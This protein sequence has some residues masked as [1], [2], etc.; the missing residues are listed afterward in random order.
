MLNPSISV[1]SSVIVPVGKSRT[2]HLLASRKAEI[3][4]TLLR[5]SFG[6]LHCTAILLRVSALLVADSALAK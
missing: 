6:H 2:P 4:R 5:H 3:D 1:N